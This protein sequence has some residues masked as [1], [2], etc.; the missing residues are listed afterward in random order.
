[1]RSKSAYSSSRFAIP[2]WF[3]MKFLLIDSTILKQRCRLHMTSWSPTWKK[4]S[5][6]PNFIGK[7]KNVTKGKCLSSHTFLDKEQE[8]SVWKSESAFVIHYTLLWISWEVLELAIPLSIFIG[9][10]HWCV[11]NFI[12]FQANNKSIPAKIWK[13]N[14]LC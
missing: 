12:S 9:I 2:W 3:P 13:E 5:Q 4:M 10:E 1:M 14:L 7:S 11:T 6:N 8:G